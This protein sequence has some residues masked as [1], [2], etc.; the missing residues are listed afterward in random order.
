MKPTHLAFLFV[1]TF[2]ISACVQQ[3]PAPPLFPRGFGGPTTEPLPATTVL[4]PRG[5]AQ[6]PPGVPAAPAP[7]RQGTA[8]PP[9]PKYPS[10]PPAPA[11][12][13]YPA[14]PL[15]PLPPSA[16]SQG[17]RHVIPVQSEPLAAGGASHHAIRVSD[18]RATVDLRLVTFS[19]R[20]CALRV[21]DQPDANAGGR[22]I[23]PL[24]RAHRAVAG[25]NGGFF[26]PAFE[27]LGRMIAGGRQTGVLSQSKLLSGMVMSSGGKSWLMWRDEFRGDFGATDLLQAGPRLVNESSPI[28][29][30]DR[31][32]AR[33]RTF[34]TTDGADGW[35][36]GVAQGVSLAS[37]ADILATP[38]LIPAHRIWR[39]LNLD[40]GNSSAIW[41]RTPSRETSDPG[42]STVRNYLAIVPR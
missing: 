20:R 11:A 10:A 21:I 40:G 34:I 7:Q 38:G 31:S 14:Q 25:V 12:A 16:P 3:Q 6:Q 37:L 42:W 24:M 8:L 30:L 17:W 22:V 36:I 41:M 9:A 32:A 39:A 26:T 33:A 1:I 13:A 5:H 28:G 35:A 4:S 19:A 15:A 2:A 29:G 18:G 23:A 27:P